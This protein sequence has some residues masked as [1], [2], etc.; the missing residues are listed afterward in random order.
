MDGEAAAAAELPGVA[1]STSS[2]L[3]PVVTGS[4]FKPASSDAKSSSVGTPLDSA[5]DLAFGEVL[6]PWAGSSLTGSRDGVE[7]A[8]CEAG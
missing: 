1:L 2:G 5:V 4:T 3:L 7:G 6:V 8:F